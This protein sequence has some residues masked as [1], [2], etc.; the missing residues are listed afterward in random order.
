MFLEDEACEE[1]GVSNLGSFEGRR[2]PLSEYR[3]DLA[4]VEED[5]EEVDGAEEDE[6]G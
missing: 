1:Y 4:R 3:V 2:L 6:A 5:G